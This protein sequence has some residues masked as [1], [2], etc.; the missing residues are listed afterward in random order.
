M[1]PLQKF[2]NN[3]KMKNIIHIIVTLLI[4]SSF[5]FAQTVYMDNTT[6]KYGVKDKEGNEF[7]SP[8]YDE[9]VKLDRLNNFRA[10][11]DNSV[12]FYNQRGELL[13][14]VHFEELGKFEYNSAKLKQK[15]RYGLINE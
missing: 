4:F 3:Y 15:N 9:I 6:G 8:A 2:I 12:Y 13:N 14:K 5:S 7:I 10:I 1:R 11:K